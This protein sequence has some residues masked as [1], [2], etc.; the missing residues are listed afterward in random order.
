LDR[1]CATASLLGFC[2]GTR[3]ST[4]LLHGSVLLGAGQLIFDGMRQRDGF[5]AWLG[6]GL[7]SGVGVGVGVGLGLGLG[8][9]VGVGVG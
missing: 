8:V 7:G 2:S 1:L 4:R 6:L 5:T 9:E 3:S